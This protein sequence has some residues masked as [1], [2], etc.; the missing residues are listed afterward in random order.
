MS[1]R[2]ASLA[3]V[4]ILV[5]LAALAIWGVIAHRDSEKKREAS[6]AAAW[7]AKEKETT[8]AITKMAER[9]HAVTHWRKGFAN[10]SLIDQIYSFEL[11]PVLVRSDGRP[12]LFI[13]S[14]YDIAAADSHYA[15]EFDVRV[16][17]RSRLRLHL[18]CTAEQVGEVLRH[19]AD[20]R[21]LCAVIAEIESVD[22]IQAGDRSRDE[23]K[24]IS[25]AKGRCVDVASVGSSYLG[26]R[27]EMVSAFKK[28]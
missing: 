23:R 1:H 24:P 6:E 7:E 17:V 25:L 22:S 10:K 21:D 20:E 18:G 3:G 27:T 12:V 19:R 2:G 11:T 14:V 8:D 9:Y 4:A 5:S 16:N 15:V 26:D 28:P 13:A